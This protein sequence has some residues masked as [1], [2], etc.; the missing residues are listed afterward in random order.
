[1]VNSPVDDFLHRFSVEIFDEDYYPDP[2]TNISEP[3]YC[4]YD[5]LSLHSQGTYLP[6]R[7]FH[8]YFPYKHVITEI[9]NNSTE[10]PRLLLSEREWTK[11]ELLKNFLHAFFN[12]TVKLSCSY[13]LSAHELLQH[14]YTIFKVNYLFE[15]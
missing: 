8:C 3:V 11:L 12:V 10:G 1:M 6:Y 5:N 14:L 2:N 9:L 4:R 7:M 13:T 15:I